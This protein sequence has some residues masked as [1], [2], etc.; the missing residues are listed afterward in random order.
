MDESN[1]RVDVVVLSSTG[2]VRA[3]V[4]AGLSLPHAQAAARL[5]MP[6]LQIQ[7]QV[8]QLMQ[9][10]DRNSKALGKKV[11]RKR[12]SAILT[13]LDKELNR[14]DERAACEMASQAVRR[15]SGLAML[16]I[17]RSEHHAQKSRRSE[18]TRLVLSPNM[19]VIEPKT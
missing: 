4:A 2:I 15:G 12:S 8:E 1:D 19:R 11:A 7:E 10:A 14:L 3:L 16:N 13:M 18:V 17:L 5:F 9:E 6:H